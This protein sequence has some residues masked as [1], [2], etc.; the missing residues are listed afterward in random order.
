M[1]YYEIGGWSKIQPI[2]YKFF[3]TSILYYD[4]IIIVKSHRKTKGGH[5]G[6]FRTIKYVFRCL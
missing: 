1:N 4:T 6:I 5:Y 2:F 3:L